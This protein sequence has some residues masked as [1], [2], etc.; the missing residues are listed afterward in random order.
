[1]CRLRFPPA[2]KTEQRL[3]RNANGYMQ[4]L[5]IAASLLDVVLAQGKPHVTQGEPYAHQ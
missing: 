4:G 3:G 1:M 2:A 5:A